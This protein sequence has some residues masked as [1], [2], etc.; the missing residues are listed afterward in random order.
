MTKATK[1]T[2][3]Q[4]QAKLRNAPAVQPKPRGRKPKAQAM[5][6]AMPAPE[7]IVRTTK[8]VVRDVFKVKAHNGILRDDVVGMAIKSAFLGEDNGRVAC[9]NMLRDN[10]LQVGRWD[11]KNIGMLRMNITNVARAILRNGGTFVVRGKLYDAETGL[12]KI[13]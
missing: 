6:I 8:S 13:S 9:D 2:K 4:R 5:V 3:T 11:G 1:Q 12:T 7:P 10:G